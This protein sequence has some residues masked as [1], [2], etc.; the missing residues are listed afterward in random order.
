MIFLLRS[1]DVIFNRK[2]DKILGLDVKT[3]GKVI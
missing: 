1:R 2:L 3:V